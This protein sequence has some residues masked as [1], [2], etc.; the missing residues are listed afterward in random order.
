MQRE[1]R[2]AERLRVS[3]LARLFPDA[4]D[5][6]ESYDTIYSMGVAANLL[7]PCLLRSHSAKTCRS[8]DY[9]WR[10]VHAD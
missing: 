4:K 10:G 6:S 1:M 3:P 5:I 2:P 9:Y 8:G 7:T